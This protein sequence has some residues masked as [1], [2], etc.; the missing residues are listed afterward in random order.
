MPIPNFDSSS[1]A[2]AGQSRRDLS[3]RRAPA[4][5]LL[6]VALCTGLAACSS[7]YHRTWA[8]FPPEPG[9]ELRI[10]VEEAQRVERF[11]KQAGVK[12]RNDLEHEESGE[13]I[14]SD[15]DRLEMLALELLRRVMTA[16]DVAPQTGTGASLVAE[17][18]QLQGRST[19]W[20]DFVRSSRHEAA[21]A[22][23]RRLEAVM[24]EVGRESIN[25]TR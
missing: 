5:Q 2:G 22:Q 24:L 15:F 4:F 12:L 20:L 10:R 16:R 21:D 9:A 1:L 19:S 25:P 23:A 3:L 14:Q 11:T 6:V 13:I 7:I 17:L 8:T 18:E